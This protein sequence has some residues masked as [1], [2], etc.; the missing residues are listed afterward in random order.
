MEDQKDQDKIFNITYQPGDS[1]EFE[2]FP[3][4]QAEQLEC[5]EAPTD[6]RINPLLKIDPKIYPACSSKS[7]LKHIGLSYIKFNHHVF[8]KVQRDAIDISSR[9]TDE[10][11]F[12]NKNLPNHPISFVFISRDYERIHLMRAYVSGAANT[13]YAFGLYTFDIFLPADYPSSPPCVS[14]VTGL[15]EVRFNPSISENGSLNFQLRDNCNTESSV[16]WDPKNSSLYEMLINLQAF[17]L[18]SAIVQKESVF[19]DLPIDSDENIAYSNVAKYA[20]FKWGIIE[21]IKQAKQSDLKKTIIKFFKMNTQN[22]RSKV[23]Q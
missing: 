5:Q 2:T 4:Y 1:C 3:E 18:D 21:E 6:S 20:N 17:T 19:H 23:Q 7:L 8:D 16:T 22:I 11:G 10:E 12:M 14:L 15:K 13:P 9:L